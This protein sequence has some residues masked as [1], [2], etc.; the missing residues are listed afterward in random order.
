VLEASPKVRARTDLRCLRCGR[1]YDESAA[2]YLC[3]SCTVGDDPSDAG[4]LD[5]Q[6][7][8]DLARRQLADQAGELRLER[9]DVFRYLPL[10]PVD[11][12]APVLPAGGTPLV[13][14]PRLVGSTNLEALFLKDETRNPSRALKDRATAIAVTR[15]LEQGH[16]DLVCA[17]AGNAAISLAAFC[18]HAGLRAHAVVPHDA[19]EVRMQWLR[20]LGADLI[21]SEFD[22]DGAYQQAEEA[23]DEGW[24][25]RNCAFNPFLVEGKKTCGLEI[26]QQLNWR[27]PDL[28]VCPV[29]DACTLASIG[30]AF[31]EL[32]EMGLTGRL[33]RLIGVQAAG[34]QPLVARYLGRD[35][36][37]VKNGSQGTTRAASINV[38]HPRN[39]RRLLNEL[40][41]CDGELLAV[42]DDQMA[43]AQLELARSAGVVAELTSAAGLAGLRMLAQRESLAGARVVAVVTGGR[44][45][46]PIGEEVT[47]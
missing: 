36:A 17:S 26:A 9:N 13:E 46:Q 42:T 32:R 20:A 6:Y 10:L 12:P 16:N 23:R 43:V 35:P 1:H 14:A 4:V 22:Y 30:K 21:R 18:A 34:V 27:V 44:L 24:Y 11:A 5:V 29:G 15:A 37:A 25:S 31:R 40:E 41:T 19:S 2:I 8:Y 7:D 3:P 47:P 39:A 28:I 33:P 45:D 38:G